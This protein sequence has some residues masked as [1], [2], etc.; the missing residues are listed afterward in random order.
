MSL[1][2]RLDKLEAA[3]RGRDGGPPDGLIC[4]RLIYDP[5]EWQIEEDEAISRMKTEV[6]DRLVAAGKIREIDREHVRFIVR[7][8]VQPS[9]RPDDA[10]PE[11][12]G[13]AAS[14]QFASDNESSR[15]QRL[16]AFSTHAMRRASRLRFHYPSLS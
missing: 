11:N 8:I 3:L 15:N 16:T 1:S 12:V 13:E 9:E 10:L 5:S 4:R 6:L 2:T 7:R 14:V